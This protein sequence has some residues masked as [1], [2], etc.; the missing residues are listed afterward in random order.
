MYTFR[1]RPTQMALPGQPPSTTPYLFAIVIVAIVAVS[2]VVSVFALR[3]DQDNT[4]LVVLILGFVSTILVGLLSALNASD[5]KSIA[6]ETHDS[7]NGRMEELLETVKRLS[8]AEGLA[9]GREEGIAAA[10]KRTD[11]LKKG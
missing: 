4:G 9:K 11:E 5:A 1:R 7:V 10:D 6:K 8:E 2:A 3:P